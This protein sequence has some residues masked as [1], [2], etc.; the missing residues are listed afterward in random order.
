MN[1]PFNTIYKGEKNDLELVAESQAGNK[2]S[3]EQL[4]L[5]HQPFVYNIAWKMVRNPNDAKDLTQEALIKVVTNLSKFKGKSKFTT[6]CYRIVLNHFLMSKRKK[7]E[8]VI[9]NFDDMGMGLDNSPSI[10]ISEEEQIEKEE[11]I[12]EMNFGCMSGMLLCLTR[13]QRL[14]YIIGDVFEAD[15]NLGAEMLDI[16]KDNYRKRLSRA[17][18]DLYNFMN[19]KCGL[20]NKNNPCRCHK[21]VTYALECGSIDSKNLLFNRKEYSKFKEV[22]KPSA[23]ILA[24]TVDEKY[25]DLY[26]SLPYKTDFEKKTFIE[27][28]INNSE[29]SRLLNLN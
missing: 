3:L 9:T 13:E 20:V 1:N 18:N 19:N 27:D 2:N 8:L 6:W 26:K 4:I 12:K 15:H 21:K 28:I 16:S 7:G 11:L 23:L 5:K 10:D 17:R 24:D 29:I 22:I 14:V 25:R